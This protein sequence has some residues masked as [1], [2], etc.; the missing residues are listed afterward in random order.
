MLGDMMRK[1]TGVYNRRAQFF[2]EG[3]CSRFSSNAFTAAKGLSKRAQGMPMSTIVLIILVILVLVAVGIM[4][5]SGFQSGA[6]GIG[7][8]TS[9]AANGTTS[10]TDLYKSCNGKTKCG[11]FCTT[12]K[13]STTY[14]P[15]ISAA[16][17]ASV[18]CADTCRNKYASP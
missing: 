3:F 17:C 2:P 13:C 15:T 12:S 9:V 6:S 10:M 18:G 14:I 7:T 4:F 16:S 1:D 11:Y 5:F 8:G